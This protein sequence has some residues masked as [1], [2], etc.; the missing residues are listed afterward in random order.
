MLYL[1]LCSSHSHQLRSHLPCHSDSDSQVQWAVDRL[2]VN[3][4]IEI[5]K[6]VPGRVSTEVDARLSFDTQGTIAKALRIIELYKE[7]GI[8]KDRILIKIASTWEGIQAAHVLE[9][10]HQIHCNLTLL[11]SF[12]Q[13][14]RLT[15]ISTFDLHSIKAPL[16]PSSHS[17]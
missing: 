14:D 11:F 15:L 13:V 12:P 17:V 6:I 3:F 10:K 1:I 9:T 8:N 4:G 7:A 2:L 16:H 5:L